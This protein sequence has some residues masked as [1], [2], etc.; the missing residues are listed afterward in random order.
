MP[1]R[2]LGQRAAADNPAHRCPITPDRVHHYI[3]V[4]CV[5]TWRWPRA[6]DL[7][8]FDRRRCRVWRPPQQRARTLL[9]FYQPDPAT[10]R[11]IAR[12]RDWHLC[13][14]EAALDLV[15]RADDAHA[16]ADQLFR[17]YHVHARSGDVRMF[18]AS[19]YTRARRSRVNV[20]YYA[21]RP[22]KV[23]GEPCLH[24]EARIRGRDALSERGI[25]S[26]RDLINFDHR[27]LWRDLLVFY[28][29]DVERF[30]RH[31]MNRQ[32][33]DGRLRR[34]IGRRRTPLI[35]RF[36]RLAID[37]DRRAGWRQLRLSGSIQQLLAD[38]R[39]TKFKVQR[40]HLI[41][42]PTE[43][44]L[45]AVTLCS[46]YIATTESVPLNPSRHTNKPVLQVA[47]SGVL[48]KRT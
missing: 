10:L 12:R 16:E 4:A 28:D 21:D 35:R 38:L 41:A 18:G 3:D 45:P 15:I 40:Q 22:S 42:I 7:A 26:A 36:G 20:V 29:L 48:H 9:F 33:N 43:C 44:L 27:Q 30:G 17:R 34:T 13:A 24:V 11:A 32:E 5:W 31:V 6:R 1:P 8:A 23:S 14:V 19:R 47:E 37:I 46:G 2:V 25:H 39:R